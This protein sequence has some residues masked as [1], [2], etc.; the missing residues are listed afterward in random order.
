MSFTN[1]SKNFN[2]NVNTLKLTPEKLAEWC[3]RRASN[4]SPL[5]QVFRKESTSSQLSSSPDQNHHNNDDSQVPS[6]DSSSQP[7][8]NNCTP[9]P[10]EMD[11]GAFALPVLITHYLIIYTF[12]VFA[13]VL[14]HRLE[15]IE[16]SIEQIQE[17]QLYINQDLDYIEKSLENFEDELAVAR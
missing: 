13:L 4:T 8:T 3:K 14:Q 15:T 6:N 10:L 9:N 11:V 2:F 7:S 16:A 5:S 1:T 12:H 17:S